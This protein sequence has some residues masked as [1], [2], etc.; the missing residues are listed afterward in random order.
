M[1]AVSRYCFAREWIE[2]DYGLVDQL[3]LLDPRDR[4]SRDLATK[5]W[6]K[7]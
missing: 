4:A 7:P 6:I 2:P 1:D 3:T 5:T